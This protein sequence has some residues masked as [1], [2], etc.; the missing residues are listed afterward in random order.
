MCYFQ[1]KPATLLGRVGAYGTEWQG[2]KADQKFD[3]GANA[4]LEF[5]IKILVYQNQCFFL[6]NKN[7]NLSKNPKPKNVESLRSVDITSILE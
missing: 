4:K 6:E 3:T 5:C 2:R 7:T 1:R